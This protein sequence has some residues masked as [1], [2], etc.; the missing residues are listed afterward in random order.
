MTKSANHSQETRAA[1]LRRASQ[2]RRA[3]QKEELRAA[4]LRAAEEMFVVHGYE[5]FS[6]RQVAEH[7]GYSP[8]TI[9]LYYDNKDDLLFAVLDPICRRF[10]EA[11][12]RAFASTDDPLPRLLAIGRA[13][14]QFGLE[15][16]T[17]YK[18]MFTQRTDFMM[19]VSAVDDEPRI[20]TLDIPQRAIV[21]AIE[22]GALRAGDPQM[23]FAC[24]WSLVHG[25]VMLAI[26]MPEK[27]TAPAQI[28]DAAFQMA[29][30]GLRAR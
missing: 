16:P 3:Q 5:N 28:L 13:Y 18:V 14:V 21:L 10:Q 8:T 11:E 17:A 1:R 26:T 25:L 29:L 2:E 9:Y 27:F 22:A 20:A 19:G 23:F 6:L 24:L 4:I 15:N 7:L 30:D 12:E